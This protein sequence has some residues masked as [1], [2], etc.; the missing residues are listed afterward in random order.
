MWVGGRVFRALQ[1]RLGDRVAQRSEALE[2]RHAGFQQL[3]EM[4]A[5]GDQFAARDARRTQQAGAAWPPG[6]QQ[7]ESG[8]LPLP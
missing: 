8:D 4:E 1:A 7:R 2:G 6:D 3:L 5:E